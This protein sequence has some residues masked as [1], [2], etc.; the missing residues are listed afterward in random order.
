MTVTVARHLVPRPD[1]QELADRISTQVARYV[2]E[3][4][5]SADMIDY[6]FSN[7]VLALQ[8]HIAAD[9]EGS[10]LQTWEAAVTAMQIGDALFAATGAEE[11]GTVSCFVLDK[12]R[13]IPAIGLRKFA[14]AGNWFSAFW[15]AVICRDRQRMTRLAEIPLERLRAA[16]S[17]YDEFVFHW[18]DVQQ[19]YWLQRDDLVEK[20]TAAFETSTPEASPN[21]PVDALQGIMYPPLNVFYNFVRGRQ[22]EFGPALA[23]ALE[24]HKAYWTLDEDRATDIDG[25]L[26]LGPFAM[27]CLAYDGRFPIDVESGYLPKYILDR[28]WVGEFPT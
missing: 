13:T 1:A 16:E 6:A 12:E 4:E 11:G 5:T 2:D 27:A 18:V 17:A 25:A 15:L 9:P 7:A 28:F 8:A 3:L 10:R 21:T 22:D 19:T 23:K 24:L 14:N 26:P 20:L